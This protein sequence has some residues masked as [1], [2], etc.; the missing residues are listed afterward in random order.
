MTSI[1][2]TKPEYMRNQQCEIKSN[3][4]KERKHIELMEILTFSKSNQNTYAS[5]S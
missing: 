2:Q 4:F 5:P 1:S 3:P